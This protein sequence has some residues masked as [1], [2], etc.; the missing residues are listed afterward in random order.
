MR[1]Q[2]RFSGRHLDV[3]NKIKQLKSEGRTIVDYVAES[4][5]I[6][7]EL[8]KQ[9]G[10]YEKILLAI[11]SDDISINS[12]INEIEDAEEIVV[13]DEAIKK[14]HEVVSDKNNDKTNILSDFDDVFDN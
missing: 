7:N 8:E 2:L 11:G 10:S 4:I 12:D 3:I 13:T 14:R 9:Y 6:R 5:R 1:Q